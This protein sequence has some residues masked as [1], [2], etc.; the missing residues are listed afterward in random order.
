MSL[1]ALRGGIRFSRYINARLNE[2][3]TG[4]EGLVTLVVPCKGVE[5]GLEEN[6]TAILEQ[7]RDFFEVLFVVGGEDDPAV[8]V[9]SKLL[10][11]HD[12]ARLIVAGQAQDCGQKV[13]N[14]RVAVTSAHGD[15]RAFVFADSDARPTKKWLVDILS[16]LNDPAIGCSTGYRWFVQQNGG[17]ATH[18]R[19]AWNASIAS[20]LG[21]GS[22]GN[23]CWGGSMAVRK[24]VFEEL[25]IEKVWQGTVSDDF[26]LTNAIK[27]SHFLIHFEPKCLTATVGDCSIG[28]LL[29]FTN[30]QMRITRIYSKTHFVVSMIGAALFTLTFYLGAALLFWLDGLWFFAAAS[31][32]AGLWLLGASKSFIRLKA[33]VRCMP[34]YRP[35]IL[36]QMVPQLLLWPIS[37]FLFLINDVNALF[38]NNLRWRG[39]SYE[40]VSDTETRII[41]E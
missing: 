19:A 39:I 22:S 18:L 28:E 34:L 25:R 20:S 21:E 15:S 26:A 9:I 24:D 17:F 30:R 11:K 12:N 3:N 29:E 13:H 8:A 5:E 35:A 14:L 31:L 41:E 27:K 33:I 40:L 10:E 7:D 23:F 6:L 32:I 1:A 2:E 36:G 16:P 37:A 38:S 4:F